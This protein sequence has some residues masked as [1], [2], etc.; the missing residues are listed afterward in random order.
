VQVIN[1]R[2]GLVVVS[3]III[4]LT[5]LTNLLLPNYISFTIRS[6]LKDNMKAQHI[7]GEIYTHPSFMI[8]NGNIDKISYTADTALIGETEVHDLSLVGTNIK[9]DMSSL[10]EKHLKIAKA[11]NITMSCTI[12]EKSL[13]KLLAKRISKV[14]NVNVD[15]MPK[16]V[17]VK[18]EI[19]LLGN[20]IL[21]NMRGNLYTKDGNIYFKV[22]ELDVE[23]DLLGKI[24]LNS[25]ENILLIDKTKLPFDAQIDTV[26]QRE[27]KLAI[28]ASAHKE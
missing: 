20:K 24:S 17:T 19:P 26:T 5:V 15:I 27:N 1:L 6:Y 21:A 28:V 10:L 4:V 9:I 12:D 25:M 18:A 7:Y 2:K 13:E 11:K 23:N 3:L 14:H 8:A 16:F 22:S